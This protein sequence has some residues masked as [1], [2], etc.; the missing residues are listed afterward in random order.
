MDRRRFLVQAMG[1]GLAGAG[2]C[3]AT[4]CGTIFHTERVGQPHSRDIDW[5]VAA[6]NGLGL[7]FFFVPG[8]VAFAVDF[9]TGAIYLPCDH[10][11]G[12][13]PDY[14][15][16]GPM[17]AAPPQHSSEAIPTVP[18]YS[19]ETSAPQFPPAPDFHT[20]ASADLRKLKIPCDGLNRQRIQAAV[21]KQVGHRVVLQD[22]AVR[23]SPLPDLAHFAQIQQKHQ[24]DSGFG[25]S[26]AEFFSSRET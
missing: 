13:Y 10:A 3:S 16:P 14:P 4:G 19:Q 8:V 21:A 11:Y 23:V 5:K 26:S 1:S 7:L 25:Y 12:G 9:Y 2:F 15:P 17:P 20:G 22:S 6:L 24:A 18:Y